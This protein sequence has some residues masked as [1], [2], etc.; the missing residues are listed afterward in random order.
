MVLKY[1]SNGT[2][3][4]FDGV[5][6]DIDGT[7]VTTREEYIE[8]IVAKTLA[9]FGLDLPSGFAKQFWHGGARNKEVIDF[10]GVEPE[11]FWPVYNEL[12]QPKERAASTYAFSDSKPVLEALSKIVKQGALTT[13][14]LP[15]AELNLEIIGGNYLSHALVIANT[16]ARFPSKPNPAGLIHCMEMLELDSERTLYVGNGNEDV[17]VAKNAG[18]KSCIVRRGEFQVTATPDFWVDNLRELIK[19]I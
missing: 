16:T 4:E 12:D 14:P 6:W 2:N 9:H 15:K 5:I 7:L 10:L 3:Y 11:E 13:S 19:Y 1:G 17:G 18:T 8:K